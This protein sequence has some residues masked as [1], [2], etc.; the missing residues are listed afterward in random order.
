M[1]TAW[2]KDDAFL[3]DVLSA[4]AREDALH[5]W[6]LGQSGFLLCH[7]GQFLLMDPYLSDSL[8]EK[9]ANTDKPHVRV[10]ERVIAPERLDF[11]DTVTASHIHTDHLDPGTVG[12]LLAVN[13]RLRLVVPEAVR[14]IAAARLDI[15]AARLSGLVDRSTMTIGA[16]ELHALPSAHD[17][18]ETDEAGRDK[19]LGYVVQAGSLRVYHSGDTRRYAGMEERLRALSVNIA[20]LPINGWAPERRVAGNLNAVEAVDV[21]VRA[22]VDLVVPHHY[23]MFAFNTGDPEEL[24]AEARRRALPFKILRLGERLTLPA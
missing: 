5:L 22:G 14:E 11:I 16:F 15:P 13:P 1:K 24:A 9:Y 3:A 7:R 21:A 6:W 20:L 10:S 8:T 4:R 2:L 19:Y 23:D 18:L 17:T 12:P